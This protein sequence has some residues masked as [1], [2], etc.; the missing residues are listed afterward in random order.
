[1]PTAS[2]WRDMV[3]KLA[4]PDGNNYWDDVVGHWCCVFCDEY[5]FVE[6]AEHRDSCPWIKARKMLS[7]AE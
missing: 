5:V 6:G 3:E 1:M 2:E 7:G 4:K